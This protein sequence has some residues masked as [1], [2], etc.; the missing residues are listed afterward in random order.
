[1]H[2]ASA[3]LPAFIKSRPVHHT[4][5]T[6]RPLAA[7]L[8][9]REASLVARPRVSRLASPLLSAPS[10]PTRLDIGYL[11]RSR[12]HLVPTRQILARHVAVSLQCAPLASV[13]SARSSLDRC[14]ARHR[15]VH[16]SSAASKPFRLG[17]PSRRRLPD[18]HHLVFVHCLS[19]FF[20]VSS[21]VD[22]IAP[23]AWRQAFGIVC[24]HRCILMS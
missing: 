24:M 13:R 22:G 16:S 3:L 5:H 6:R 17:A 18:E 23:T 19:S 10:T 11:H 20:G 9:L 21:P 12:L 15:R 2:I 4:R 14:L 1:V 8:A 7:R